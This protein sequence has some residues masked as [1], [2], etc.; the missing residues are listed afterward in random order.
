M[1][2]G[3]EQTNH[4]MTNLLVKFGIHKVTVYNRTLNKAEDLAARF[5]N[6]KAIEL[7]KLINHN[8]PID[9]ILTCTGANYAVITKEIY[10]QIVPKGKKVIIVDLAV[11]QDVE[12]EITDLDSVDYIDIASLEIKAKENMLFRRGELYK[13]EA[14]LKNSW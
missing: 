2:I 5:E 8:Q 7:D 1:I 10:H 9:V 12:Q 11:P 13:A 6:G 3:A 4:L 14:M